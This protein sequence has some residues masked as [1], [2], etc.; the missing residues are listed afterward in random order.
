MANA[1]AQLGQ[2]IRAARKRRGMT[3][4]DLAD[5]VHTGRATMA[6]IEKGD[7][8]V[9]MGFYAAVLAQLDRIDALAELM[10]RRH[11]VTGLAMLE[12][13]VLAKKR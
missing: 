7:P 9:S 5:R 13:A 10:D 2:D 4:A 3:M 11:D 8:S 12:D 1:L 6:R